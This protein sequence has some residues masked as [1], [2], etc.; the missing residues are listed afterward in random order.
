MRV[1]LKYGFIFDPAETWPHKFMFEQ[2]LGEFFRQKGYQ[3]EVIQTAEGQENI[4]ML[5]ITTGPGSIPVDNKP[6]DFKVPDV[7]KEVKKD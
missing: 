6:V 3:A 2:D 7:K 4:E 5:L 1:Y